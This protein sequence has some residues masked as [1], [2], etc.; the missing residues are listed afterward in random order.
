MD[1]NKIELEQIFEGLAA[2]GMRTILWD[3]NDLLVYADPGMHELYE[4]KEFKKSFGNVDLTPGMSWIDWTKQEIQLGI[5][6]TPDDMNE[7]E[8][9]KKL[10]EDRKKIR[11]KR[12]RE[13]TF[14]NGV[15]VLSTDVR[16][17]SGG[18][19]SNFFD[20]TE[21]K[22]QK[23][24]LRKSNEK[25]E[26]LAS[27]MDKSSSSMFILD[28]DYRFVFA[29]SKFIKIAE[30]AG[31]EFE[32]NG[33]WEDF[34]R[35]LVRSEWLSTEGVK[36]DEFVQNRL[37]E[38][39]ALKA[40]SVEERST[41]SG[42]RVL[43]TSRLDDGGLVQ[44]HTDVTDLKRMNE[45]VSILSDAMNKYPNGVMVVDKDGR[46]VFSNS[47]LRDRG[48]EA[49]IKFEDGMKWSDYFR[50]LVES[51]WAQPPAGVDKEEFIKN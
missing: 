43:T 42:E 45:K 2:S 16:L 27:A 37:D 6:Q 20:I 3:V 44:I 8:Y 7:T 28:K 11:D 5:I 25:N 24:E 40:S 9:L 50:D 17:S 1:P 4:S 12:T 13:I 23:L 14:N 47:T 22:N 26:M 30:E 51:G 21:Q 32:E 10:Q 48:K 49:G 46:F 18:L 36:E 29:N 41:A 38:L 39:K 19:F 31:F 35:Q 15:T 33:L 34:F